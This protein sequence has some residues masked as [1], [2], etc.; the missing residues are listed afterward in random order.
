MRFAIPT[1]I[2]GKHPMEW[3]KPLWGPC[4]AIHFVI[5]TRPF[6]GKH[7]VKYLIPLL[8]PQDATHFVIL[9]PSI[10]RDAPDGIFAR[11]LF[12]TFILLYLFYLLLSPSVVLSLHNPLESSAT[13]DL[14]VCN[15]LTMIRL[16]Q[17]P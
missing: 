4:D 14:R 9:T 3:L 12:F 15:A 5:L 10:S 17:S 6:R 13:C 11:S 8:R 2:H 7:P 1:P 16:T